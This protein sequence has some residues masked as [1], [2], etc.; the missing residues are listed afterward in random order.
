MKNTPEN[1][2]K[3]QSFCGRERVCQ[4]CKT[5][6]YKNYNERPLYRQK[7]NYEIDLNGCTYMYIRA[8]SSAYVVP[9]FSIYPLSK[10]LL[11]SRSFT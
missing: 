2:V 7:F 9:D 1:F 6:L 4:G 3:M 5:F 11:Y 8:F 10:F